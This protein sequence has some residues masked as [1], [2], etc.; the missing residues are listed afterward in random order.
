MD[1]LIRV[2]ALIAAEIPVVLCKPNPQYRRN[3]RADTL[4]PANW[5]NAEP[6]LMVLE[7]YRPGEH[8]L[9]MVTGFGIDVVDL[10]AKTGVELGEL[11]IAHELGLDLTPGGGW[12][13]P[14]PGTG[15]GRAAFKL[16]GR[17]VGDYLGGA[18]NGGARG[19]CYLPGSSRPK[20]P[21]A[22]YVPEVEWAIDALLDGKPPAILLDL[23]AAQGISTTPRANSHGG[24]PGDIAGFLE[25]YT[26]HSA[27]C[28]Y[29]KVAL[30]SLL[31]EASGL[32]EGGRHQWGVRAV[33]RTTELIKSGCLPISA[34]N[35]VK[36]RFEEIKPEAEDA[37]F[38]ELLQWAVANVEARTDCQG[39][40]LTGAVESDGADWR[41]VDLAAVLANPTRPTPALMTRTDGVSLLYPGLIHSL[42]GESESGKSLAI[43]AVVAAEVNR[44]FRCL[45]IDAESDQHSI[46]DRLLSMGAEPENIVSNLTYVRPGSGFKPAYLDQFVGEYRLAVLDGVTELLA[47]AG[48]DTNNADAIAKW[49]ALLPNRIASSTN[50]AVVLIDHQGKSKERGRFSIGSQHKM[51]AVTGA[52]YVIEPVAPIGLGLKGSLLLKVAK[53]RPGVIRSSCGDYDTDTRLQSAALIEIDA[54]TLPG[55]TVVTFRPPSDYA[56]NALAAQVSAWISRESPRWVPKVELEAVF[57]D[58]R[59]SQLL[60]DLTR[61]GYLQC[62]LDRYQSAELYVVGFSNLDRNTLL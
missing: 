48:G 21:G 14:V 46:L 57:R 31:D 54:Q 38:V 33:A 28:A 49:Y 4:P 56:P 3:G 2:Q 45:Y 47:L 18:A 20:Y 42:S 35:T 7:R 51:S 50:A 53:D 19:L 34:L 23:L 22:D 17:V 40:E 13:V 29:G 9:A 44:G 30:A 5:Q 55:S 11:P 6:D 1:P 60:D 52:A 41:P 62:D 59:I 24:Q 12:H 8:V 15:Y 58:P 27:D 25:Q 61:A 39:H 37:E 43:L 26:G 16:N 32:T 36:D 10:D